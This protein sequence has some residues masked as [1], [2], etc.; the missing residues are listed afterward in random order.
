MLLKLHSSNLC[1]SLVNYWMILLLQNYIKLKKD[2]LTYS[3]NDVA[4]LRIAVSSNP[5]WLNHVT[6][7]FGKEHNWLT[8]EENM[9]GCAQRQVCVMIE[10]IC[11]EY[12]MTTRL[13][14]WWM[15]WWISWLTFCN[16]IHPKTMLLFSLSHY[17][18]MSVE[19]PLS[20]IVYRERW[21]FDT[22]ITWT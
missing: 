17:G 21:R 2:L 20:C 6:A 16:G 10:Q 4:L 15:T 5:P 8:S 12:H 7:K 22:D 18:E 14:K 3:Q 19:S 11:Q 9:G 1:V 13:N